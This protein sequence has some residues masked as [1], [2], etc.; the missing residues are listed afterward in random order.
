MSI[1]PFFNQKLGLQIYYFS[2]LS[3]KLRRSSA[4][5]EFVSSPPMFLRGVLS[6]CF[7]TS[8]H[9]GAEDCFVT[10][11]GS[12]Q[13]IAPDALAQVKKAFKGMLGRKKQNA[14]DSSAAKHTS[15]PSTNQAH[16]TTT[17]QVQAAPVAGAIRL[18]R[19][20]PRCFVIAC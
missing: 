1:L 19:G 3:S 18:R 7:F 14:Q 17:E 6:L 11:D 20:Q 10:T 4:C 5:Q 2:V 15:S 13:S 8:L 16:P 12:G 9:V